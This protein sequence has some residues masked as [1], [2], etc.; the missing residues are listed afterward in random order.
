MEKRVSTSESARVSRRALIFQSAVS[1][2]SVFWSEHWLFP[3]PFRLT[4]R[5]F[6]LLAEI[7]LLHHLP[8]GGEQTWATRRNWNLMKNSSAYPRFCRFSRRVWNVCKFWD[9]IK[10]F[11]TEEEREEEN[12][13]E[14]LRM[15]ATTCN[16]YQ[17]SQNH[18]DIQRNASNCFVLRVDKSQDYTHSEEIQRGIGVIRGIKENCSRLRTSFDI[19]WETVSSCT[20]SPLKCISYYTGIMHI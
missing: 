1:A 9:E 19:D 6:F 15:A 5:R 14:N 17:R 7:S 8:A 10:Y 18:R 11:K 2:V 3:A 20:I 4:F 12:F 16:G 13:E